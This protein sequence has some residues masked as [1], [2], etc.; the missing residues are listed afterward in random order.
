MYGKAK[1]L[2]G[3]NH[4]SQHLRQRA[5]RYGESLSGTG[6][7]EQAAERPSADRTVPTRGTRKLR[8]EALLELILRQHPSL[9]RRPRSVF[10]EAGTIGYDFETPRNDRS[11]A[12]KLPVNP[13]N[14]LYAPENHRFGISTVGPADMVPQ[15]YNMNSASRY[16]H[17][18]L[19]L[20]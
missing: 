5:T 10:S 14:G 12:A 13:R 11:A 7:V 6:G 16:N 19:N 17:I 15:D 20:S 9:I 8:P 18:L 4:P 1:R 2:S 3:F